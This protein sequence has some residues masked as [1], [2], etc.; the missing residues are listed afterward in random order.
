MS[1]RIVIS[2]FGSYGDINPYLGLAIGLRARGHRPVLAT[3]AWYRQQVEREGIEFATVRPDVDPGDRALIAKVMD[4]RRGSEFLL[5]ELL[6]RGLRDAHADLLAVAT[7]ADLLVSHVIPLTGA[8]VAEQLG[9]RWVSAVLS[10]MTFFSVHDMP[11]F[12]P[13][14][15]LAPVTSIPTVARMLRPLIRRGT[16]SWL[17]PLAELRRDVGMSPGAHPLFEGMHSPSR[18]L[19]LFSRV[20]G[21]PQPDWPD[22]VSVTGAIMYNGGVSDGLGDELEQVLADGAPPVVFTLGSSAVGAPGRFYEESAA[23][24][25]LAGMRAVLMVGP[26]ADNRPSRS[27]P[28]STICVEMA[29]HALLLPRSAVVVHQAGIGTL[30]QA[31]RSGQPQL[32]VP[33]ANDQPDNA[34]RARR[35]GVARVINPSRYRA[36]RVAHAL[37]AI[38]DDATM[39]ARAAAVGAIVAAEDGLGNACD[40]IEMVLAS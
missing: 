21:M 12:A 28:S 11:V 1:A 33:Y 19:G 4:R 24:A 23:A 9:I 6:M 39:C 2:T 10:P 3:S 30:H 32:A 40:E 17:E 7:G 31:L 29:P 25:E 18:V 13:A 8:V 20:V 26:H 5:R 22:N 37:G 16:Q 35:L 27:L 36:R 14:P 38:R 34:E 15:W